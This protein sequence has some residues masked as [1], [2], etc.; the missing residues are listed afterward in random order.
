MY[1]NYGVLENNKIINVAQNGVG[2]YGVNGTL[3]NNTNTGTINIGDNGI[4]I[5]G[6]NVNPSSSSIYGNKKIE[7]EHSGKII[8]NGLNAAYGIIAD[9]D[10]SLGMIKSDSKITINSGSLIDL[11]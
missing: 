3:S 5:Y 8:S 7:I 10:L 11:S 2:L 4:G 1:T 9:N 6:I